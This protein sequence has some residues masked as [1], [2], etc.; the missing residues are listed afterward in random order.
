MKKLLLLL[1]LGISAVGI[2]SCQEQPDES[3]T[4]AETTTAAITTTTQPV[5]TTAASETEEP[6][7]TTT[8]AAYLLAEDIEM[9]IDLQSVRASRCTAKMIN[10]S[11]WQK[12]Y[13]FGYRVLHAETGAPCRVLSTYDSEEDDKDAA[14]THWIKAGE[15]RELKYD[16]A[17]RYGDLEDG[18]Y[19]LELALSTETVYPEDGGEAIQLPVVLRAEFEVESEG[20]VPHVFI[21]PEDIQPTGV[22]L[23]I[24]NSVDA[25]RSYAFVYRLYDE[26][27]EPRKMLLR[28]FDT[29]AK[30]SKNYYVKAGETM[31]LEINWRTKFGY[32]PEGQ[33]AIEIEMLADGEKEG[34]TYHTTF[35][36]V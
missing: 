28:E 16:W 8:E 7:V 21:A 23:T 9:F 29:E 18:R 33:Y 25:G 1:L 30:L 13:T 27:S 20:F 22:V 36:I 35:E 2:M 10:H 34:K 15:K 6:I 26:S 5:T 31:L 19:I 3:S 17:D 32:L 4:E 12:P 14:E 11:E 24:E